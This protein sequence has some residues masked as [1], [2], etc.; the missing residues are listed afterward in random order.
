MQNFFDRLLNFKINNIKNIYLTASGGP[1]LNKKFEDIK[2]ASFE[3]A[4]QH[5]KWHMGIKN[6]IDSATLVNKCLEIIEAHYLF[7]IEYKKLNILIHPE[8]LVHSI[9]EYK[10]YTSF[11][12]YFYHDMDIPLYNFLNLLNKNH[13]Y[14][15]ISSN[16]NFKKNSS[17]NFSEPNLN[18]FPILKIFNQLDKTVHLNILKFNSANEFAVNLFTRKMIKFSDIYNIIDKSLNLDV[19]FEVNSIN[20]ILIYQDI[21]INKIKIEFNLTEE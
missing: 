2:N 20:N 10:N 14:F 9:I 13:K 21:F 5:P 16:Y 11:L 18:N 19:N 3:N 4:V 17:L 7:N 15:N 6:S 8:A 12:N 1:F